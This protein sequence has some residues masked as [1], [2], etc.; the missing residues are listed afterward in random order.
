[1]IG[2]DLAS[3][4]AN[5]FGLQLRVYNW[6]EWWYLVVL[7]LSLWGN[8]RP[9]KDRWFESLRARSWLFFVLGLGVLISPLAT[10]ISTDAAFLGYQAIGGSGRWSVLLLCLVLVIGACFA[11]FDGRRRNYAC[12]AATMVGAGLVIIVRT[13]ALE[14]A[15][16]AAGSTGWGVVTSSICLLAACLVNVWELVPSE[17]RFDISPESESS[18]GSMPLTKH[19]STRDLVMGQ[20]VM[21]TDENGDYPVSYRDTGQKVC[22]A[23]TDMDSL[24]EAR[25]H[26]HYSVVRGFDVMARLAKQGIFGLLIN[27][28]RPEERVIDFETVPELKGMLLPFDPLGRTTPWIAV[29]HSGST[30]PESARGGESRRVL[31]EASLVA[32]TPTPAAS[33]KSSMTIGDWILA[34]AVLTGVGVVHLLLMAGSLVILTLDVVMIATFGVLSLLL[35]LL[36]FIPAE[37]VVTRRLAERLRERGGRDPLA[38][39]QPL[40][41]RRF[42]GLLGKI[43]RSAYEKLDPL[44]RSPFFENLR[45]PFARSQ[46]STATRKLLGERQADSEWQVTEEL[47]LDKMIALA[48]LAL[49]GCPANDPDAPFA[50]YILGTA[51]HLR[52]LGTGDARDLTRARIGLERARDGLGQTESRLRLVKRQ[53][54]VDKPEAARSLGA[55]LLDSYRRSGNTQDLYAATEQLETAVSHPRARQMASTLT[56]LADAYT[57]RYARTGTLS[58]LDLAITALDHALDASAESVAGR[59]DIIAELADLYQL[60][61]ASEGDPDDLDRAFAQYKE[62]IWA[63]NDKSLVASTINPGYGRALLTRY[64]AAHDR[65]D[66]TEAVVVLR[67]A[68][69]HVPVDSLEAADVMRTL[70][71]VLMEC[72]AEDTDEAIGVLSQSLALTPIEAPGRVVTMLLLGR[73]T[74]S[75]A[76]R[77][78]DTELWEQAFDSVERAM[79]S[80]ETAAPAAALL[81]AADVSLLA[82]TAGDAVRTGHACETGLNTVGRLLSMQLIRP[83]KEAWLRRASA[84][85]ARGACA[86]ALTGDTKAAAVTLERGRLLLFSEALEADMSG[87]ERLEDQEPKLYA[88]YRNAADALRA[89]ERAD[90]APKSS[91]KPTERAAHARRV[92]GDFS[93][94]VERI[95]ESP[96]FGDFLRAPT[97]KDI[98]AAAEHPL[99]YLASS[100]RGGMALVVE[101]GEGKSPRAIW[102]DRLSVDSVAK[103]VSAHSKAYGMH[104][105]HPEEWR[106]EL[107]LLGHWLWDA[108]VGPILADVQDVER[109]ILVPTGILGILPFHI[110]W[111]S[112]GNRSRRYALDQT[113][114][115][116]APSG[117]ALSSAR[118]RQR[119][120]AAEGILGI[121]SEELRTSALEIEHAIRW[122]ANARTFAATAHDR[123]DILAQ[124]PKWPTLH[125]ACHSRADAERPLEGGLVLDKGARITVRDLLGGDI[126]KSQLVVLSACE[127][128]VTG[129]H[130]PDEAIGLPTALIQAGVSGVISSG[131][132]VPDTSSFLVSARF[133]ELWR[134]DGLAPWSALRQA[135]RWVRDSTNEE[136]AMK[137]PSV[138]EVQGATVSATNRDFWAGAH[139]HGHPYH[140]G[141]FT[142]SGV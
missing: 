99:V 123:N 86:Q 18:D 138:S 91:L 141:A 139:G 10:N 92:R 109:V 14:Q 19:A 57:E 102:L 49:I 64:N 75:K 30:G 98:Q 110:A 32:D 81:A 65:S 70:G 58:D 126:L 113:A 88:E 80:A 13:Q 111:T 22:L 11:A 33:P 108:A 52:Y 121:Y 20:V 23:Y 34:A 79:A 59:A 2:V 50:N 16:H 46:R 136:K 69:G 27:S 6:V 60:R 101:P 12:I 54:L 137:F 21:V 90:L 47:Q 124:L 39:P 107:D 63:L 115:T 40:G 15:G 77:T 26:S 17:I 104:F 61:F 132:S 7:A 67:A 71:G 66:L 24:G 118:K 95:R 131:W 36:A 25:P 45:H 84:L 4:G 72:G 43:D 122:F 129:Q 31:N 89:I 134:K 3:T 62:A 142:Y 100:D 140:W 85:S 41:R 73:A 55:V 116:Y 93:L 83:H 48:E 8:F 76:Q 94:V 78:N 97:L 44:Q 112:D 114:I 106:S 28:R 74:L 127:T 42:D 37:V 82:S 103:I 130:L 35:H 9:S 51:L 68:L 120:S 29:A 135:Q 133:H 56:T 38:E 96:G 105:T 119:P 128:G 53:A 5:V 1:M 125:F 117:R 87:V